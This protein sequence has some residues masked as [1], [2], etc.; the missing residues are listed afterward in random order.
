MKDSPSF[1][2]AQ[3]QPIKLTIILFISNLHR[4]LGSIHNVGRASKE[5][6]ILQIP[7][8]EHQM[9]RVGCAYGYQMGVI[10]SRTRLRVDLRRLLLVLVVKF[11]FI[12]NYQP[13]KM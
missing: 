5:V 10:D 9:S 7:N 4:P 2:P 1:G 12:Q 3:R 6:E 13:Q 11:R 8:F